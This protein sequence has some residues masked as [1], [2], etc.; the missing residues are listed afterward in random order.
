[1]PQESTRKPVVESK[2]LAGM[3]LLTESIKW[4]LAG[5]EGPGPRDN[6]YVKIGESLRELIKPFAKHEKDAAKIAGDRSRGGWK[7][8]E[9]AARH[10]LVS[11][12][13]A[14]MSSARGAVVGMGLFELLTGNPFDEDA[15]MDFHNNLVGANLGKT[16]KDYEEV[17]SKVSKAVDEAV[18]DDRSDPTRL[19][20]ITP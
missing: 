19:T 5:R 1:M 8:R 3:E 2:R 10:A 4:N 12:D 17:K 15:R 7:D 9:D 13:I 16:A 18:L 6:G 20:F 11:A 14:R